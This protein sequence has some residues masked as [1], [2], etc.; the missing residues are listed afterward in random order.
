MRADISRTSGAT[1]RRW[2]PVFFGDLFAQSSQGFEQE[3]VAEH[4]SFGI[5]LARGRLFE[6]LDDAQPSFAGEQ[7]AGAPA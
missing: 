4:V 6:W 2:D 5:G 7:S 1:P 3:R